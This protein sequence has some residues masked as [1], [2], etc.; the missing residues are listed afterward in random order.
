[1]I[2]INGQQF[3]IGKLTVF[4]QLAVARKLGPAIPIVEGLVADRN[5]GKDITLLVVLMLSRL[6]DAESDEIVKKCL[7]VV[8]ISQEGGWAKLMPNGVLMFSD[9]DLSSLL[10]LT[11]AVIVENLGTFFNTALAS[12]HQGA[13]SQ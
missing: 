3:E 10:Q 13:A 4:E 9:I 2:E 5:A 7:S 1:M 8:L 6:S 12:L 11:A